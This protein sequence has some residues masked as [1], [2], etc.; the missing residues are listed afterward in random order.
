MRG[1][2]NSLYSEEGAVQ[3]DP[4]SMFVNATATL[5]LIEQLKDENKYTQIWY[6]DDSSAIGNID[7]IHGWIEK[8]N[9]DRSLLWI[10]PRTN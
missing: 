3:G 6:A 10:F 5:P 2:R 8:L 7:N 9:K 1:C 4:L